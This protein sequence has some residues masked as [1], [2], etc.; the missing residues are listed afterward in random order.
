MKFQLCW[1]R[2]RDD[3]LGTR[4][5][6]TIVPGLRTKGVAMQVSI[7]KLRVE[8]TTVGFEMPQDESARLQSSLAAASESLHDFAHAFLRIRLTY[9]PRS[10]R[11]HAELKVQ[12]PGKSLV[13]GEEDS[14]LDC[15]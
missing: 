12:V 6:T 15:A 1:S 4:A 13:T 5:L 8:V 11:Y 7:G 10:Q 3:G 9:H 14:Y 2:F